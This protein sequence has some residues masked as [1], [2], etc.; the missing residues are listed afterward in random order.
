MHVH[1]FVCF[2]EQPGEGNPALVVVGGNG[3]PA[4]RQALARERN[5]TCVFLDPG[6]GLASDG[7]NAAA[8][9][10]FVYPHM[11]SPL[12]LHATLAAAQLLFERHGAHQPLRV[13]TAMRGQ[14][15]LLSRDGENVFV[16]LARQEAPRVETLLDIHGLLPERLLAAPDLALAS[17]PRLASVGSPKLLLEVADV[18]TLYG[19]APDL[20]LIHVWGKEVGVNGCYVWCRTNEGEVEGRNFNHLEP[21]LEDS[22][23]GVAAGALTLALGHGLTLRQ[24]RATGRH[25]LI[26]T[27]LE[28]ALEADTVLVGGLAH[29][30]ASA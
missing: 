9:L 15:L 13:R 12:C 21:S 6:D 16:R 8:V 17:A 23:T 1:E 30:V 18:D 10:D 7:L 3:N 29:R 4:W 11:R 24:G 25:C 2:G 5:L 19:L 20:A 28:G 26:R 22:A 27:A 14:P